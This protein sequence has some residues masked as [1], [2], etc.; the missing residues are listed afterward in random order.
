MPRWLLSGRFARTRADNFLCASGG[1]WQATS[2]PRALRRRHGTRAWSSLA[3]ARA[4]ER[5]LVA[6]CSR[7]PTFRKHFKGGITMKKILIAAA[8]ALVLAAG[9]AGAKDK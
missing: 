1:R 3:G 7:V 4:C 2:A 8:S 6:G 9:S 5:L